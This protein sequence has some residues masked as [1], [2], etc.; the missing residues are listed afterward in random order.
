MGRAEDA[1][2]LVALRPAVV[3]DLTSQGQSGKVVVMVE[4]S[5]EW[6]FTLSTGGSSKAVSDFDHMMEKLTLP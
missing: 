1:G 3:T 4:H 5:H 2:S 6:V